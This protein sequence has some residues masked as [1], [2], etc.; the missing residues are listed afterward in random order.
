MLSDPSS[1]A[2]ARMMREALVDAKVGL[3]QSRAA[4][5]AASAQLA[6]ERTELAT[7]LRRGQLAAGINDAE[8]VRLAAEYERKHSE[9]I[10]V[11]ERKLA[12]L[13]QEVA[14]VERETAEMT[15]QLK[16]L[17]G[18]GAGD[19]A[20]P[21]APDLQAEDS[22]EANDLSELDSLRRSADRTAREADAESRLADL[23]RR[24]GK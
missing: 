17:T 18:A 19:T 7:V 3:S 13:E 14:L 5:D 23:K 4:R 8:T 22:P 2:R 20:A 9:R 6:R 21:S 16:R 12:A 11:L 15:A 10:V 1:R 24:M